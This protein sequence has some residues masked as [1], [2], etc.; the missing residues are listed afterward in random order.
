M[1]THFIRIDIFIFP[2][3]TFRLGWRGRECL[4]RMLCETGRGKNE[5]GT[6]LQE[7]MRATLT[8]VFLLVLFSYRTFLSFGSCCIFD[9]GPWQLRIGFIVKHAWH[10][11]S[12]LFGASPVVK[13]C[14]SSIAYLV[15]FLR[16]YTVIIT[17]VGRQ[18]FIIVCSR[19]A[20]IRKIFNKI[21]I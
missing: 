20:N 8:W 3:S 15:Q 9:F 5:Q 11:G 18:Y 1:K 2:D 19:Y 14:N 12:V 16:L 4:L 21:S 13:K 10:I 6:F 7:I 17:E